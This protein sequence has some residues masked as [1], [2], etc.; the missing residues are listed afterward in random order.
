[1][2]NSSKLR[3]RWRS[4]RRR[5]RAKVSRFTPQVVTCYPFEIIA[6]LVALLMGLPFLI[7]VTPPAALI[8][9]VGH[10]AFYA[11]SAGLTLGSITIAVGLKTTNPLAI[12]SGLQ[13]IAGCFAV[14]AIAIIA[15][16]GLAGWT[17]TVV[18]ICLALVSLIRGTFFRR[19]I[20]IQSRVRR[21]DK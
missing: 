6:L 3:G 21:E 15:V 10:V 5:M 4:W 14:Y 2:T 8:A 11:W 1:M 16:I 17:G 18:Y 20:D 12:A 19:L 9:I 13:L 7:G